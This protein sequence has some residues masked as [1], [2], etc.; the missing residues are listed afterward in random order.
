MD[1]LFQTV[2]WVIVIAFIATTVVTLLGV[3]KVIQFA[4]KKYLDKLFIAVV[5]E[6]VA[7]GFLI[8][9]TGFDDISVYFQSV[10][11]LYKTASDR[12]AE[13]NTTM[14]WLPTK[15]SCRFQTS[16]CRS[17]LRMSS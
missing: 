16:R 2:A 5:L 9:R 4:D 10:E 1:L 6:V 3:T 11:N 15:K 13:K 14:H 8:F 12:K 17:R 7:V